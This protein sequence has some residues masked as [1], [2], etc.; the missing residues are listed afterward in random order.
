VREVTCLLPEGPPMVPIACPSKTAVAVG[1]SLGE[2]VEPLSEIWNNMGD[3]RDGSRLPDEC[4]YGCQ[5]FPLCGAGC[6]MEAKFFGNKK[7]MHPLA[8]DSSDVNYIPSTKIFHAPSDFWER[9]LVLNPSLRLRKESFGGVIVPQGGQPIFIDN[10]AYLII[11]RLK[12]ESGPFSFQTIEDNLGLSQSSS[13]F[14]FSLFMKGVFR[15]TQ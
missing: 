3:W 14:F 13:D 12:N 7:A 4:I 6:R 2:A 11:D 8:T 5:Y 10:T 1:L 15:E 9:M